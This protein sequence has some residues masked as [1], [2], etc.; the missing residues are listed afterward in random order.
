MISL[1]KMPKIKLKDYQGQASCDSVIQ[2]FNPVCV[3]L[4]EVVWDAKCWDAA[5][6]QVLRKNDDHISGACLQ[7]VASEM[8]PNCVFHSVMDSGPEISS[9]K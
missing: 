2:D 6:N 5:Q 9:S 1:L 3:T 8:P 7:Q 4:T